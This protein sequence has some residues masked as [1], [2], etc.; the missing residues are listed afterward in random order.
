M[1]LFDNQL[2]T[3]SKTIGILPKCGTCSLYNDCK[4]MEDY[5]GTGDKKILVIGAF[6]TNVDNTSKKVFS[7][8]TAYNFKNILASHGIKESDCWFTNAIKQ[9]VDSDKNLDNVI[10]F[11]RPRVV[12]L[13]KKLQP[14]LVILLG[15]IPIKSVIG[16]YYAKGIGNEDLWR[17]YVI[18]SREYKTWLAPV[19][20]L[21]T[22]VMYENKPEYLGFFN[23]D[24]ENLK[25]YIDKP[26]PFVE[27]DTNLVYILSDKREIEEFLLGI[28]QN[29]SKI[30]FISFDY[31]TSGIKPHKHGHFIHCVSICYSYNASYVFVL[32][33]FNH[34]D[35]IIS[36]FRQ[37]MMDEDIKKSAHNMKF[38]DNWTNEI[39]KCP[40]NGWYLDTCLTAH[41]LDNRK[42]VT[43]LKFQTFVE[44]GVDD[45]SSHI[46]EYLES[47]GGSNG[48]NTVDKAPIKDI[49]VYCGL[50]SLYQYR[51]AKKHEQLIFGK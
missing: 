7:G 20:G 49:L 41:L 28:I 34:S 48:I 1:G 51:L 12:S 11:C 19:F 50:D 39:L 35:R 38:E 30:D 5:T 43:G 9:H 13:I 18:P 26:L 36:L 40:V 27:K 3:V 23:K 17:G 14:K 33:R 24:I 31:E 22:L 2:T 4:H 46:Q 21:D 37:I 42:G 44:F 15:T 25:T 32:P 16:A 47:E 10:K 29:K 6:P 45:Y 8:Q